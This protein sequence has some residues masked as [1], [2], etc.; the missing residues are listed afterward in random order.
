MMPELSDYWAN[1]LA[2]LEALAPLVDRAFEMS[3]RTIECADV[4]YGLEDVKYTI[5]KQIERIKA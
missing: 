2:I 3:K 5:H 1:E 4:E